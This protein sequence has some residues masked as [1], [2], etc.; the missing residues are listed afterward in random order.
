MGSMIAISVVAAGMIFSLAVAL[1]IEEL[2]FGAI[3]RLFFGP[4][5]AAKAATVAASA[6]FELAKTKVASG[7]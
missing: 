2:I 7:Q 3:F 1:L 6:G 5:G 4:H